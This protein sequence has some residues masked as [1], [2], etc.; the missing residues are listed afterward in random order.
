MV[1]VRALIVFALLLFHMPSAQAKEM[2][3]QQDF[4]SDIQYYF[5]QDNLIDFGKVMLTGAVF[6]NTGLDGYVR[7]R[8]RQDIQS[9]NLDRVLSVPNSIADLSVF[10]FPVYVATAL[11]GQQFPNNLD[12]IDAYEWGYQSARTFVLA[13]VQQAV[14][15]NVLGSGR[16][17]KEQPSRWAPF[18]YKFGVSGHALYGAVPFLTVA[19]M[20]ETPIL[21]GLMYVLSTLP[22]LS[23]IN[24]DKHYFSQAFLGWGLA[25]LTSRSVAQTSLG[26]AEYN[27]FV[28]PTPDNGVRLQW[29]AR[30]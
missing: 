3:L 2:A 6:A 16:P 5:A 1:V 9:K 11:I 27:I 20:T 13:G 15:T 19:N 29:L 28:G 4:Q 22:A 24:K 18:R 25:F 7:K 26:N 14:L 21:K 12:A 23:R 8:W 17:Y 30:F 10:F